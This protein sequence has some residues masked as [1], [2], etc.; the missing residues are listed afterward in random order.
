MNIANRKELTLDPRF[1][2]WLQARHSRIVAQGLAFHEAQPPARAPQ[3]GQWKKSR[4]AA[5]AVE[6]ATNWFLFDEMRVF[7]GANPG[8]ESRKILRLATINGARALGLGGQVGE[9]S[10]GAFADLIAI[11]YAGKASLC[12]DAI[13]QHRGE[14]AAS[15][16]DGEWAIMPGAA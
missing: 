6:R 13:V 1:I 4:A 2:A 10:P 9:L 7:G 16:I 5:S 15:M 8:M 11:P 3:Q 14:V 12:W